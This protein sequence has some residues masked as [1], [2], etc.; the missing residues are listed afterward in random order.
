MKKF[1][2]WSL[3]I[4]SSGASVYVRF[5]PASHMWPPAPGERISKYRLERLI[6]AGGMGFVYLARDLDLD[7]DVAI[8][9]IAEDKAAD[10]SAR[11]RLIR[12]ARAAAAL[13]HP[14]IC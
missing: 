12:E 10:E 13:D 7:R 3:V 1:G 5:L 8:K 4:D 6:G 9:F 14:N 11:R 2:H